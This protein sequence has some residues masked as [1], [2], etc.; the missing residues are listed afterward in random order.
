VGNVFNARRLA[1]F[2]LSE[3]APTTSIRRAVTF[4]ISHLRLERFKRIETP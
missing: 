1:V 3:E 4:V 2:L